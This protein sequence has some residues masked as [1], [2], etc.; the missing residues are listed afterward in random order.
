M[1]KTDETKEIK[2]ILEKMSESITVIRDKINQQPERLTKQVY[3]D[4]NNMYK[5]VF[6]TMKSLEV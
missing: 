2:E 3:K 6:K 1:N 5:K 4:F